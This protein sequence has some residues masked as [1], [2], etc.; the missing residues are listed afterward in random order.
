M[1]TESNL[2]EISDRFN[3]T[4]I[5]VIGDVMVDAYLYGKVDRI[6][7]EAPVPVVSLTKRVEMPGGAG[8]VAL[9]VRSLGAHTHL[10]AA[11]GEDQ[12]GAQFVELLKKANISVHGMI[13]SP[14]R[15]TTTKFRIIGNNMQMLRVDEES[16]NDLSESEASMLIMR[17][18]EIVSR[19]QIKAIILQDYNK[20]VLSPE[21]IN[22]IISIANNAGI[23]VV[24][25]PKKRNFDLYRNVKLFKPNLKELCEGVK[26]EFDTQNH[27]KIIQAMAE[28]QITHDVEIM[29]V[30]L[31]DKGLLIRY[32]DTDG[33]SHKHFPAQVRHVADVSGAGDTVISVAALGISIGLHPEKIAW[34]SNVAGGIVCEKVGVVA[35]NKDQLF[36][37]LLRSTNQH[38]K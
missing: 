34:M 24:V 29:M 7:P 33:F 37:E 23:P 19:H 18:R 27:Q 36:H 8:N 10:C 17:A 38:R 32:A 35:I 4:H 1:L 6:S 16:E 13:A 22:E 31:G 11:I 28:R 5:L 30:T 20:G 21:V 25:D 2:Q 14:S 3:N 26:A 12:R 15:I 9:N